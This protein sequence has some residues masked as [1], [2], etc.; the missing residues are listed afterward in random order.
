MDERDSIRVAKAS[1]DRC[2]A[3]EKFPTGF[4]AHFFRVCPEAKP[5]FEKTDL[6]RQARLLRNA[7]GL[8]LIAPFMSKE[9]DAPSLLAKVA[10]R[11][12][13]R[14]LNIGPQFYPPFAESLVTTIKEY[15]RECT[16]EVEAAWR[17]IIARGVAYMQA[18]Y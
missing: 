3:S 2:S 15:D 12:S 5:L 14:Q 8:L 1:F 6:A 16:P 4:Y 11:H 7:I 17:A 10:E 13:R 18:R 9:E